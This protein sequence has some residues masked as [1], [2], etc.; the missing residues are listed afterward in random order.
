M[1]SIHHLALFNPNEPAR[2][3]GAV[4]E[5]YVSLKAKFNFAAP[6]SAPGRVRAAL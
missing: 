6:H 3:E 1:F 2:D 4:P 5:K